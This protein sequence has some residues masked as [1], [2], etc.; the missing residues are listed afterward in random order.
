[1]T[2]EAIKTKYNTEWQNKIESTKPIK[3]KLVRPYKTKPIKI[4]TESTQQWNQPTQ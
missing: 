4:A 1:M 3:T 2:E